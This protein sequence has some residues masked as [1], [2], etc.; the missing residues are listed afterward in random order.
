MARKQFLVIY[1]DKS[2]AFVSRDERDSML[3]SGEIKQT[4]WREYRY[5]VPVIRL[6]RSATEDTMTALKIVPREPVMLRRFLPG[7][8]IFEH[9]DKRRTERLETAEAMEDSLK[10]QGLV[11]A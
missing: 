7:S 2:R 6:R 11:T 8:F 3:L 1:A 10:R 4:G 9:G 5:I